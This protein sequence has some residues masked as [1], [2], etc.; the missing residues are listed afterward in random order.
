LP[1][2]APD[3]GAPGKGPLTAAECD[4][5]IRRFAE[6]VAQGQGGVLK[7]GWES[8]PL[9][10]SMRES[11]QKDNT[12]AQYDCAMKAKTHMEWMDCLR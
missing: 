1:T 9:V 11:C 8:N 6:L 12:R 4:K 2:A 3:K 5:L 7:G 10:G